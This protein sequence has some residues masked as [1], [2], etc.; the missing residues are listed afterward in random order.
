MRLVNPQNRDQ[1]LKL[2][3]AMLEVWAQDIWLSVADF[4]KK[5]T[6]LL[7]KRLASLSGTSD[8]PPINPTLAIAEACNFRKDAI[9]IFNAEAP[10]EFGDVEELVKAVQVFEDEKNA[11]FFLTLSE[12]IRWCWVCS[13][14]DL[15]SK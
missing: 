12:A 3:T 7:C 13:K 10:N 1:L 15:N 6:E 8:T 4:N 5:E 11:E 14:I 2:N 9:L